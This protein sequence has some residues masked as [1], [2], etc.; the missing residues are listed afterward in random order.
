MIAIKSH[1]QTKKELEV[2]EKRLELLFERKKELVTKHFPL[3]QNFKSELLQ[4]GLRQDKYMKYLLDLEGAQ[5]NGMNINEEIEY[6]RNLLIPLRKSIIL[7]E[8]TLADIKESTEYHLYYLIKVK[9]QYPTKA[10]KIIAHFN[11]INDLTPSSERGIWDK[12]KRLQ[13]HLKLQ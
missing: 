9:G 12:Y 3:T 10:V 7:I 13:K 4:G 2:L 6:I 1:Q 11:Y 8:D 5:E